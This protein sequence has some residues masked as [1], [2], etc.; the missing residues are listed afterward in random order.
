MRSFQIL[1]FVIILCLNQNIKGQQT[2]ESFM[3]GHSLM[4]HTSSTEQTEIA[5]WINE[6]A[7]EAGHTYET[8]GTFGSIW[9]FSNYTPAAQMG[10][11]GVTG[12]W[13]DAIETF[14]QASVT[15]S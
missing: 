4:D 14:N 10:V 12:T 2:I 15:N 11:Q 3:F 5:Y 6:F 7:T 9:Q 13:D 1:L 8:G